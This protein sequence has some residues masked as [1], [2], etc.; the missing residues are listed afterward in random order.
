MKAARP[1]KPSGVAGLVLAAGA[2]SRMGRSKALLEADGSTFVSRLVSTLRTGGCTPVV[3]VCAAGSGETADEAR[4]AG[5]TVA[6]NPKGAGGQIASIRVG[7]AELLGLEE[8][9]GAV[10]FTPVDNP[11]VRADTVE[12]LIEAWRTTDRDI[13]HPV[14]RGTRGHPVLVDA[15]LTHEFLAD[16][17]PD[18]ARSVVRKDPER[19]LNL[20]VDDPGVAEDLDTP[21]DY[22]RFM[23]E[24]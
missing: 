22:Q 23:A 1:V 15:K 21:E 10:V 9:P 16:P 3:V 17:L 4:K 2:S 18:G 13:V 7:L 11:G 8:P 5:G 19:V 12:R 6:V 24:R 20:Q 14:Y